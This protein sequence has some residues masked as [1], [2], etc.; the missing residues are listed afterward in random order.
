MDGRDLVV[1]CDGTS[2]ILGN[3]RDTNVV[4]LMRL[5]EKSDRQLVYYDPAWAA[6][7]PSPAWHGW[8]A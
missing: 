7:T 6:P 1:C 2:N 4:K 3:Q 8:T 5:C